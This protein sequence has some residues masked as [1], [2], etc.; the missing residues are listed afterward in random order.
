MNTI[1]TLRQKGGQIKEG[2][3]KMKEEQD[4]GKK[5]EIAKALREQRA[6]LEPVVELETIKKETNE[7]LA[8]LSNTIDIPETEQLP[9]RY[10]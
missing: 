6:E 5:N 1:E 9:E 2:L 8:M 10:A 3:S 4:Q 7:Q